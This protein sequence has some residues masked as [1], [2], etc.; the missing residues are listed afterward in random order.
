MST[1]AARAF[2]AAA[3]A[4]VIAAG[5]A[6]AAG[7]AGPAAFEFVALGDMPYT[8]PRDYAKFD[9][10]IAAIN[11]VAPAFSLHIGD[12]KSGSSPCTDEAFQKVFD[13]FQSFRQPLVYTP[14]DNEW[15]DCHREKA[16]KFD[17]LERLAKI[18][19]MFFKEAKSHGAKPLDLT[20]QSDVDE[21]YKPFVENARWSYGG[22]MFATVHVVGSNNN[23]LP[24]KPMA[25][26]YF[27]RNAANIAWI[28]QTFAEAAKRNAPALVIGMQ[29]D[30][31]F[32]LKERD[33]NGFNDTLAALS[34][35][36]TTF[37]KPVLLVQGDTH[38]LVIDQPLKAADGKTP[39]QTFT[40]LQVMGADHVHAVRVLVDPDNPA[41]FSFQPLMVKENMIQAK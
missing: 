41:V 23:L 10:L 31:Q 37:G 27:E 8:L 20:R 18:R 21:T 9:A 7:F 32:A 26:E 38:E 30:P 24:K 35:G 13:Q 36:A 16:G 5:P 2:A 25:D 39:L 3:F 28:R 33:G 4:S 12:I 11:G 19:G 29:A 22:V 40:R 6:N 14:G 17:P 1:I 34:E 15:T